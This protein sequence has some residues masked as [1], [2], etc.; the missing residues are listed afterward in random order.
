MRAAV[1]P[2]TG[3]AEVV[4]L[5]TD[6]PPPGP[7][8]R[9]EILVAVE[10]AGLDPSDVKNRGITHLLDLVGPAV[11]EVYQDRLDAFAIA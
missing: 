4:Q 8:G 1:V 10:A 3:P 2:K 11:V 7:P 9:G 6:W 5:R